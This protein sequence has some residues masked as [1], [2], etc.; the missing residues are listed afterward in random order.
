M[1]HKKYISREPIEFDEKII[2]K[3][4]IDRTLESFKNCRLIGKSN[5]LELYG[6]REEVVRAV[7]AISQLMN[8]KTKEHFTQLETQMKIAKNIQ[9]QYEVTKGKWVE[10]PMYQNS[11]I[12]ASYSKQESEVSFLK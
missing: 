10:F 7:V 1:I 12:E 8:A 2:R 4:E 9:W 6:W 11:L 3:E 5:K